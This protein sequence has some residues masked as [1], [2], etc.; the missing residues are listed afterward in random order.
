[1]LQIT[2]TMLAE[3]LQDAQRPA[4]LLL[5]VREPWEVQICQIPGS[6][7]MPMG[8]VPARF[9]ELDRDRETVVVCHHG[10]RSWQVRDVPRAPGVFQR[11]QPG[12]RRRRL[13]ERGR[14]R[15]CR[16]TERGAAAAESTMKRVL[17]VLVARPVRG[18]RRGGRPDAGVPGRAR[19]RCEVLRCARAVRGRAGEGGAGAR[20]AVAADRAEGGHDLE[21][22]RTCKPSAARSLARRTTTATATACS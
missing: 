12:R 21:R 13:G 17:A 2:P 1:M 20:R 18:R 8:S 11:G 6:L 15:R 22:C 19:Q 9:A 3:R 5:D 4:P 7:T 10:G 14:S 16:S